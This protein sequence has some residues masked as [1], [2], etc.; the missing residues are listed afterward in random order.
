MDLSQPVISEV[1]N[2]LLFQWQKGYEEMITVLISRIE[3]RPNHRSFDAEIEIGLDGIFVK[4]YGR[5]ETIISGIRI[6]LL[7]ASQRVSL[8]KSCKDNAFNDEMRE[9]DW[10]Q[11][12][13]QVCTQTIRK[14]R[15][16]LDPIIILNQDY[17]KKRPEFLLPPLFVKDAANIIYAD[18][19][20][21]KSLFVI[22]VDIILS[23]PYHDNTL[24]L[25][26]EQTDIHKVLYCD[27]EGN[28]EI[29][30]WQKECL[31]RGM[32]LEFCDLPY[33]RCSRPLTDNVDYLL[34]KIDEV[35]ADTII[36]DSLGMAVGEDL[37]L[38][39]P[40]FSFF[41]GL[42]QLPVTP[43]I[44]A[45][46]AKSDNN[47]RTVYGNAYYENEARSIWEATKQQEL[48]STELTLTLHQRKPPPFT[49]RHEPLGFRFVFDG[50]KILVENAIAE[51][52]NRQ[53]GVVATEVL[54]EAISSE[55]PTKE[56][57]VSP[58]HLIEITGLSKDNIYQSL[59]RLKDKNLINKDGKGYFIISDTI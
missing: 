8:K 43:I 21:A 44:V 18:R 22:L 32:G 51:Q 15:T 41:K 28:A 2:G 20:S 12:V 34:R 50:N 35:K 42:R 11:L 3:E 59:K 1:P 52:D 39:P 37:N 46:T 40:A 38:T 5:P 57:R 54:L 36:I 58:S 19:S 31:L 23:L 24:G 16:E 30:G 47:R 29:T 14:V 27:W 33:L 56:D 13:E 55:C 7:S 25:Y 4:E 48:N 6:N 9:F 17:G 53:T 49:G 26:I 10:G 45:H